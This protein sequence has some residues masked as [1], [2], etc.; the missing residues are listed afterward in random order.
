ML[1]VLRYKVSTNRQ[2]ESPTSKK[3]GNKKPNNSGKLVVLRLEGVAMDYADVE[4]VAALGPSSAN[5][6]FRLMKAWKKL[7]VSIVRLDLRNLK[8]I[9]V[10]SKLKKISKFM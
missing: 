2:R 4:R 10:K 8:I 6:C 9:R 7:V 1:C 5:A 3:I